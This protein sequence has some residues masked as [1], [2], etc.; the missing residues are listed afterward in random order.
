M[1]LSDQ[2]VHG[3]LVAG[4]GQAKKDVYILNIVRKLNCGNCR[5]VDKTDGTV[6]MAIGVGDG[7]FR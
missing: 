7:R 2:V 6:P 3:F 5:K 1:Q 4:R